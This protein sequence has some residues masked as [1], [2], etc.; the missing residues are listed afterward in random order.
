MKILCVIDSLGSGGAQRQLVGLAIAFKEKGNDI[1]FLVYHEQNFFKDSL[2][3]ENIPVTSIIEKN[4]FKRLLKMRKHIRRGNYH[5]VLSFLEAANFICE[6]A[7]LPWRKW[8]L[9]VGERSANPAILKSF[10]L[11]AYRWFHF[12]SDYVVANSEKNIELVFK[13]NPFLDKKKCRVI[14]NFV[15]LKL[16]RSADDYSPLR[17]NKLNLIVVASHSHFKNAKG[18]I[19]A[20]NELNIQE[21]EILKITWYGKQDIDHSFEETIHLIDKYSLWNIFKFY[22]PSDNIIQIMKYADV[23]GLFSLFEGLPNTLCEGMA[24]GKPIISSAVS[25]VPKL[26]A[27]NVNHAF[28]PNEPKDIAKSIKNVLS[29]SKSQL[30]ELGENYKAKAILLFS[31]E[32]IVDKYLS[33]M[34]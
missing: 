30:I 33:L 31:K 12:L 1:S 32:Q 13:A 6:I 14:Y 7:G 17:N 29:L 19:K 8:K 9:I 34:N 25:D 28:N 3:K 23:V 16:W 10:K 18:L 15:D 24:L 21:K 5:V 22:P 11:R 26:I 20:V 27:E 4:Y 2:D